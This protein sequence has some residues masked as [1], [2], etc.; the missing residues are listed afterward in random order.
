MLMS[1]GFAVNH[2]INPTAVF[3][4]ARDIYYKTLSAADAGTENGILGWCEYVLSNLLEEIKKI[5][6]LLDYD[7]LVPNI[8]VPALSYALSR[9]TI[10]QEEFS[11]LKMAIEKGEL[12]ASDINIV[13]KKSH[14]AQVSAYIK[15]LKNEGLLLDAPGKKRSYVISFSNN[16]LLRGVI[17]ALRRGGFVGGL[18]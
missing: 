3:C 2:I 4:N 15:K 1:Q 17:D 18:E 12:R 13:I 7:Y 16:H 6:R 14:H 5:D 10:N 11:I 8:L 9:K